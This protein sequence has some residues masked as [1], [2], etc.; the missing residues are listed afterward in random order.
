MQERTIFKVEPTDRSMNYPE[1]RNYKGINK[2]VINALIHAIDV[3][4]CINC[5]DEPRVISSLGKTRISSPLTS[6]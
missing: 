4:R 6:H 3:T 5:L 2:L 1:Y